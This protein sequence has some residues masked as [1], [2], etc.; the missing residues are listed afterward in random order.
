MA[1]FTPQLHLTNTQQ[2]S[3]DDKD[4]QETRAA[5]KRAIEGRLRSYR[6]P[7]PENIDTA[8]RD[9]MILCQFANATSPKM[10]PSIASQ[11]GVME[12]AAAFVKACRD[13]GVAEEMLPEPQGIADGSG[14]RKV[15]AC[16]LEL[17]KI[18]SAKRENVRG[19]VVT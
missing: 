3:Q 18:P 10:V 4:L 7:N 12:N 17:E 8:L 2:S 15:Y 6:L 19:S 11:S 5:V 16:V 9:G 1:R 14:M 13:L